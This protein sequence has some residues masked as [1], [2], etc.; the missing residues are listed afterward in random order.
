M[1]FNDELALIRERTWAEVD[2][3]AIRHN[4][5]EIRRALRPG[6]QLCCVVKA[7]AY[8]HGA[9]RL[10]PLY[11]QLG[12][13]WFAVSNIDE[14]I[15]LRRFGVT[16][17]VLILGYTPAD[18]APLL[19]QHD[20]SQ[21]VYSADYG[22]GLSACAVQAGV[23]VKI[24]IKLDTG[25][26]RLG[27]CCGTAAPEESIETACAVC[28]LPGLQ[29]EG[30]FTHFATADEGADGEAFARQQYAQFTAAVE[31]MQQQGI[32]F[33]LRH[34][35]NSAALSEYPDWQMDMVRAGIVLYGLQPSEQL[36]CPLAL[37]PAM[38]LKSVISHVK[39]VSP[40][41]KISYG[42]TYTAQ[43]DM[44]VATVPIGYAD[45]FWRS[46]G[47]AGTQLTVAGHRVPILGRVCMDQLVVDVTDIPGVS[48]GDEVL[49]FGDT[50]ALT[51]AQLAALN[52][53]IAYEVIC[54]VGERV[55]RFYMQDGSP[56]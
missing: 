52:D 25:M 33:V 37:R 5:R 18:C 30:V 32:H 23:T 7:N 10:A 29:P 48:I 27:F 46:N 11:E 40:G 56:V 22:E 43:R 42:G 3:D 47:D 51:A 28:R 36:R 20:L 34:C 55:P 24:H 41:T 12:A 50:P 17:P 13:D 14:A 49:V 39:R 4:Y 8:G 6:V 31:R 26:G 21:C 54:G 35:A 15:Q 16:R 19:A 2:L 9:H 1:H 45:G 53:T 44:T 38:W